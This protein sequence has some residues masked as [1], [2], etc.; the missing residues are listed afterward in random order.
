[1]RGTG[2]LA[3]PE[4]ASVSFQVL[5]GSNSASPGTPISNIPVSFTLSTDIH[6]LTLI[7][8]TVT[9]DSEGNAVAVV[10][11]GNQPVTFRVTATINADIGSGQIV[12]VSTISTPIIVSTGIPDQNS[13]SLS[14]I[15]GESPG[16]GVINTI[17][18]PGAADTDGIKVTFMVRMADKF[19]NPVAEGTI[20]LFTT[21]Y[22]RIQDSCVTADGICSVI[23][24]SQ[25]PR[26]PLN[27]AGA[28]RTINTLEFPDP[29]YS[30]SA[31]SEDS[32]PCP[33]D[34]G[35]GHGWRSTVLVTAQG[36]E[37]FIDKNSNGVYDF[38][39]L[40]E[41]LP[42]AFVDH[43]EDGVFT[44]ALGPRCP[45]YVDPLICSAAGAEETF[46]DYNGDEAYSLN[47]SPAEFNG[48]LC[49]VE[50]DGRWCSRTQV[51]VRDSMVLVMSPTASGA[52]GVSGLFSMLVDDSGDRVIETIEGDIY[53]FYV[54]DQYNN[55]PA[56][57]TT[58]T[59]SV[60]GGC[61]LIQGPEKDTIVEVLPP[62]AKAWFIETAGDGTP[63]TLKITI[64][65]P[66]GQTTTNTFNC[67]SEPDEPDPE[68]CDVNVDPD[69]QVVGG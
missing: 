1:M 21:E 5:T 26:I 61:E 65:A 6:G 3:N 64:D 31:H 11:A 59:T 4:R 38:Q 9:S 20:A 16:E 48:L 58:I 55:P 7:A 40:W 8:S 57:G 15:L 51:D 52:S 68:D 66:R 2:D 44:P 30:C 18:V 37:S 42:E 50:G 13:I 62:G 25:S 36:E 53:A 67:V 43:N 35:E 27:N 69:C 60:T 56:V 23:W 39:E 24:N 32:G 49:P 54:S 46:S 17:S 14:A 12:P 29:N 45:S 34:F 19:N 10:Q 41:N 28:L 63:G 22:G 33:E 47:N